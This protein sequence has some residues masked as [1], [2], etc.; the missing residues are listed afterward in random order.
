MMAHCSVEGCCNDRCTITLCEKCY[1]Y[2][3][4]KPYCTSLCCESQSSCEYEQI[5][6]EFC[7]FHK[8]N[9]IWC[10]NLKDSTSSYCASHCCAVPKCNRLS[11]SSNYCLNHISLR[12]M[13]ATEWFTYDRPYFSIDYEEQYYYYEDWLD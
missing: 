6:T 12:P 5:A 3:S 11:I 8:C 9:I 10:L 2:Y 13:C 4:C 7:K 1:H